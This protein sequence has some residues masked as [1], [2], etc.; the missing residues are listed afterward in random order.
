MSLHHRL[1]R[2]KQL[3]TVSKIITQLIKP[4]ICL[5]PPTSHLSCLYHP[6]QLL[7][8]S[9]TRLWM[10][11]LSI[12]PCMS[13]CLFIFSP[14]YYFVFLRSASAVTFVG[15]IY[16]LILSF[17]VVVSEFHTYIF[18]V[19]LNAK[20]LFRSSPSAL[21]KHLDSTKYYDTDLL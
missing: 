4:W 14:A 12:N 19:Y 7:A 5:P 20:F 16:S 6:R 13:C 1:S 17:F 11:S 9:H 3:W 15:L 18:G 21:A 10:L 8:L 2:F